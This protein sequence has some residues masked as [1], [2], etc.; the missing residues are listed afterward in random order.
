MCA[1]AATGGAIGI[2]LGWLE[3]CRY[4]LRRHVF[5]TG[6]T[7]KGMRAPCSGCLCRLFATLTGRHVVDGENP[8]T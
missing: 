3:N 5:E 2:L 6:V 1:L 8:Q 7:E 4:I